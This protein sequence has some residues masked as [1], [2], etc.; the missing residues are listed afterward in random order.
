MLSLFSHIGK[1]IAVDNFLPTSTGSRKNYPQFINSLVV[2]YWHEPS[3]NLRTSGKE[4]V[5][6]QDGRVFMRYDCYTD[7]SPYGWSL[8]TDVKE[9]EK[10]VSNS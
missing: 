5:E 3:D 9:P 1:T 2:K 4:Y 10:N 7:S 6:V 8:V